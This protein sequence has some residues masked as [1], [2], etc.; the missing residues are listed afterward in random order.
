MKKPKSLGVNFVTGLHQ[1]VLDWDSKRDESAKFEK[2]II[3]ISDNGKINTTGERDNPS[4][5]LLTSSHPAFKKLLEPGIK[6][7]VLCLIKNFN[8]ITYSS[9]EGHIHENFFERGHIRMVTRTRKEQKALLTALKGI[10]SKTNEEHASSPI[11]VVCT[12]SVINTNDGAD[13]VGVDIFFTSIDNNP[14]T[15]FRSRDA[16]VNCFFKEVVKNKKF[17]EASI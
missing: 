7:A 1:F 17:S 12:E 11:R 10:V 2:S 5:H 3:K 4:A 8:V 15:Y 14:D 6:K 16:V 13:R 9:C